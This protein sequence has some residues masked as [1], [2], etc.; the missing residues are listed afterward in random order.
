MPDPCDGHLARCAS[1]LLGKSLNLCYELQVVCQAFI[2]EAGEGS[3]SSQVL[4]VGIGLEAAATAT[5][6]S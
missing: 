2:P 1:L 6:T 3:E 5:Y 4:R